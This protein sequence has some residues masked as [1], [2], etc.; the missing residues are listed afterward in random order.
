MPAFDPTFHLQ[1]AVTSRPCLTPPLSPLSFLPLLPTSAASPLYPPA[2]TPSHTPFPSAGPCLPSPL[3][4]CC[5]PPAPYLPPSCLS[6][7]EVYRHPWRPGGDFDGRDEDGPGSFG[8][9]IGLGQELGQETPAS[10]ALDQ[11]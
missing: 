6:V 5:L 4:P 10:E 9:I 7:P 1:I 2:S 8:F 11:V 3:S